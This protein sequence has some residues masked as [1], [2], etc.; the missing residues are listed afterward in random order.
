MGLKRG[1]ALATTAAQDSQAQSTVHCCKPRERKGVRDAMDH[2]WPDHVC[3]HAMFTVGSG[4]KLVSTLRAAVVGPPGGRK[5]DTSLLLIKEEPNCCPL[6]VICIIHDRN[7][8]IGLYTCIISV[9]N[10]YLKVPCLE[11]T[12][13]SAKK[14][15]TKCLPPTRYVHVGS[16][17]PLLSY[18]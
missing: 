6:E 8:C 17:L 11:N 15:R 3:S 10:S 5:S 1:P 9:I 4:R 16:K 18:V 14:R 7:S 13:P 2:G 12:T